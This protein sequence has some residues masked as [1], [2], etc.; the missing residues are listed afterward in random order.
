MKVLVLVLV[1][2]TQISYQGERVEEI[3]EN[4]K[5]ENGQ[6]DFTIGKMKLKGLS[7][8]NLIEFFSS[9]GKIGENSL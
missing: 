1:L 4:V 9:A 2:V 6:T 3:N 5:R 7:F 8:V